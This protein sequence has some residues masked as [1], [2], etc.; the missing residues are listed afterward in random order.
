MGTDAFAERPVDTARLPSLRAN[1]FP[2]AGPYPWLDQADAQEQIEARLRDGRLTSEEAVQCR[3]WSENGYLIL[4]KLIDDATLDKVWSAYENAVAKGVI[5]LKPEPA[6][7][8]DPYP[9]RF[10]DPHRKVN[11][12]CDILRHASLLHWTAAWIAFED[13]H[14]DCGPLLYYPKSHRLPYLFA[15]D[16]GISENDF[17]QRGY[18][19]YHE[20]YEPRI[21]RI[22]EENK[23]EAHHFHARKG[24]VLVWHANLIHGGSARRNIQLSR[25]AVVCHFFVKG[26]FAYHDLSASASKPFSG[27]CLLRDR[28]GELISWPASVK[29]PN[30]LRRM[31]R[32]LRDRE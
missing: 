22:V 3:F 20:K 18:A 19:E 17:Q 31:V 24:D 12:F 28:S 11:A 14:P 2:Y 27:T 15:H 7:E 9:G 13:I 16:V 6:A 32:A 25:K 23:L 26:S 8:G 10:L 30:L 4:P 29:R 21:R 5:E 1:N